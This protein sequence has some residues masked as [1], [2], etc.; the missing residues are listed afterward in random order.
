VLSER[1]HNF[2]SIFVYILITLLLLALVWALVGEMDIYVRAYGEVRPN[3][4]IST[5]RSTLSGRV[6]DV[7]IE[8]GMIVQRGDTLF[9]IDVQIYRNTVEILERQ[10]RSVSRE[11][12]NLA[13]L[14]ESVI[15]HENLFNP[16]SPYETDYFFKYQKYE[17]DVKAAIEQ[18]LNANLDI[19]R[20]YADARVA[21]ENALINRNRASTELSRMNSLLVSFNRSENLLTSKHT[22]QYVR[23]IDYEIT[24][25]RYESAI[26]Q[27]SATLERMEQLYA[28]GGV[29]RNE[30]DTAKLELE[31]ILME[32]N[33]YRNEMQIS[34]LQGITNLEWSIADSDALMRSADS[35][36][37]L[38]GGGYSEELLREKHM[39]DMLASISDVLFSLQHDRDALL[40]DIESLRLTI[41]EARVIA[42][43]D[44]VVSMFGEMNVGDYV[45]VG[46]DIATILPATDGEYRVMLFVSNVDI[47]DIGIGQK[48]NFRFAALPFSEYGE[49]TG[50]V[51][52]ISTD[53]RRREDGQ[54]IFV[55]EAEMD[56][57]YLHD[58]NGA[59]AAIR[60]GMVCDARVITDNQKIIFWI[61]E[62]L[63]FVN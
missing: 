40:R 19:E 16:N 58:R 8:D 33:R 28:V 34:V 26:S 49:M 48:I 44:G 20:F 3:D 61:L 30:R 14:R 2:V 23:Y 62:R 53:A 5:I 47:A 36:L 32:R 38:S 56:G 63:N 54:S 27:R 31:A 7:D 21:S 41:D 29:S 52:R 39:L 35:M 57:G 22:E 6:V 1:P 11:I 15:L 46:M 18:V 50:R 17:T 9:T 55:V 60:V 51:T 59:E 45:Q 13:L 43:I 10:F 37:S 24:L 42:P 4:T 12:E 25:G